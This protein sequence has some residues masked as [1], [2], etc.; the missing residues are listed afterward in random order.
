MIANGPT[1]LPRLGAKVRALRRRE[2]MSQ[3]KLA[4]RLAISPSY[5]NL[6]ENNR[7][8]LPAQ[9]LIRLAQIFNVELGA[10]AGDEDGRA[11]TGLLEAFADPLFEEI[12]I[13]SQEVRELAQTS[14]STARAVLKLYRA[15][16]GARETS[17][18][19]SSRVYQGEGSGAPS[20]SNLPS[21]EVSDFIQRRN[22]HFP[23]LELAAE[24]L[25]K[26]AKL[27]RRRSRSGASSATSSAPTRS[28]CASPAASGTRCAATSRRR[29][30]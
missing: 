16:Q 12:D 25:W 29:G 7:R 11:I 3:A 17:D 2:G 8:P 22:N 30:C 10:F 9:H 19:L 4:E 5:L 15:Y 23:E 27:D 20:L 26:K 6:I 21:E 14:P 13:V 18:Q 24:Q 1:E 28:R